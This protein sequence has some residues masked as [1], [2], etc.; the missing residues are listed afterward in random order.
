MRDVMNRPA[1]GTESSKQKSRVSG[2]VDTMGW[3]EFC[4]TDKPHV[5]KKSK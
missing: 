3:A 2:Q 5:G 1:Y 4:G